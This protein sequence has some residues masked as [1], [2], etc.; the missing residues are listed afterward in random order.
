[1]DR[2]WKWYSESAATMKAGEVT[3]KDSH[4]QHH[5]PTRTDGY[6]HR[7]AGR[8]TVRMEEHSNRDSDRLSGPALIA[9]APS[10]A[11]LEVNDFT[12]THS[13]LVR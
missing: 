12:S 11:A 13:E 3:Q 4:E 7:T 6:A 8:V 1:M 5:S 2:Y 9:S 10:T